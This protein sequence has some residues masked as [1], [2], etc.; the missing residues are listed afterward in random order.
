MHDS[1]GI[2]RAAQEAVC[3]VGLRAHHGAGHWGPSLDR[4]GH[5]DAYFGSKDELF[6]RATAFDLKLPDLTKIKPTQ[7]GKTLVRH[8]LEQWEGSLSNGSL[9]ILL[10]A[11]SS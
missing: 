9:I 1:L 3:G 5:V 10:R 2:L 4:P 11:S 7:F 8:F 6:A